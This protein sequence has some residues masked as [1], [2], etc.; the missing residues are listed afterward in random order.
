VKAI[1]E[2]IFEVITPETARLW[3]LKCNPNNRKIRRETVRRYAA[4][5]AA[6]RFIFNPADPICFDWNGMLL[7]GQHRLT[8]C[9]DSGVAFEAWACRNCDP[10]SF[11]AMDGGQG[12]TASDDIHLM[13]IE[14]SP[15][16]AAVARLL[17]L[18]ER[19]L[20]G[21][22]NKITRPAIQQT[23]I[24]YGAEIK[25]AMDFVGSL[26]LP[27]EIGISR[28]AFCY[29]RFAR[30]DAEKARRF[31]RTLHDP[32]GLAS[33]SPVL[34]LPKALQAFRK[35][36]RTLLERDALGLIFKAWV[37]FRDDKTGLILILKKTDQWWNINP[38]AAG[39]EE[40]G[41]ERSAA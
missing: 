14:N 3:L 25:G 23:A 2:I 38:K 24:R 10:A 28:A 31:F 16:V 32:V 1:A 17:T 26:D 15:K 41:S 34:L 6:G 7:N 36:G 13:G 4:D 30:Q 21:S 29:L 8:A 19:N 37:M 40:S 18:D 11:V 22:K 5:M 33:G 12:R 39:V 20:L 35:R 27:A 9:V